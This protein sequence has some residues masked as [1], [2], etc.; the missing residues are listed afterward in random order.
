MAN[1]I[2]RS[3]GL[4]WKAEHVF[5][6]KGS[7]PG[8]LLGVPASGRRS[9]PVDLRRQVGI[10][11]L[12][13]GHQMIYVGQTGAGN[14]KLFSR[15]KQHRKDMLAGRWDTFSWFG[16][17][18][19]LSNGKLSTVNQRAGAPLAIAL[20]HMEAIL[21]ATAEPQLN[22]QGGRFGKG[23]TRYLQYRDKKLGLTDQQLI[24]E[25]WK[26]IGSE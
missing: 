4:F 23:V 8:A 19:T 5:W 16:L 10:Y 17:L 9:K 25:I 14:Q 21:I 24:R 20:N 11:V 2:I 7:Q 12:Y 6:G 18:Y 26:K 3:F 15:L 22:R 1:V 13:S